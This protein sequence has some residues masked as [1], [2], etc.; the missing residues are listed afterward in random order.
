MASNLQFPYSKTIRENGEVIPAADH[1]KQETQLECLTDAIG[2]YDFT[3]G[4]VEERLTIIET[5]NDL[6]DL[7]D[8]VAPAPS[9]GQVLQFSGPD[10][11]PGDLTLNA[12]TDVDTDGTQ[13]PDAGDVLTFDGTIWGPAAVAANLGDLLDVDTTG[14]V[15]GQGLVF[16]SGEWSPELTSITVASDTPGGGNEQIA[17]EVTELRFISDSGVGQDHVATEVAPG[18]V[19][20]GAGAPPPALSLIAGLPALVAGR[21]SQN[22]AVYPPATVAGDLYNNITQNTSYIFNTNAAQFGSASLGVLILAINGVDVATLDLAANFVEL[23]RVAGQNVAADYNT[24][25][26]GDP[27]VSGVVTFVGG[28]LEILTVAPSGVVSID[29]FQQGMSRITLNTAGMVDGYNS[30]QLRH[31]TGITNTSNLLEW[32][33]DA[34]LPTVPTNPAVSGQTIVENTPVTKQL[35]GITYYDAGSTFDL[36]FSLLR[37]FNNV[38]HQTNIP[39]VLDVSDFGDATTG[40]AIT[41]PAVAGVST[42]P[43]RGE[44]MAVTAFSVA[45]GGGVQIFQPD[46]DITPRDPYGNY[47]LATASGNFAIMSVSPNSTDTLDRFVDE[48][49]RLPDSTDFDTPI[50][51]TALPGALNPSLWNSADDLTGTAAGGSLQVYRAEVVPSNRLAYPQTDY[52][53]AFEPQPNPDYS[54]LSPGNRTYYRVF[55][56]GTGSQ[57][58]GIITLPGLADADLG[59]GD[60]SIRLKVPGKTV[61]LDALIAFSAGTFPTGAPLIGGADGEGCRINSGVNSPSINGAIEFSLGAIGTDAGSDFQIIVEITYA[62]A[63]A[64]EIVGTGS[65]LSIN[66]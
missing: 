55:R 14:A 34:D 21:L 39:D 42:P 26:A 53:S 16:R 66:W 29:I 12:L 36:D 52:T 51:G 46:A 48:R 25:G 58:N 61:W 60:V 35:S 18:V 38:Y 59:P 11:V 41:D 47:T 17:T 37:P 62:D 1:N 13:T 57:T 28:T 44:T 5:N 3:G 54:G 32:F 31:V 15:D 64:T 43:D 40:I 27:M 56:S 23:N 22:A 65:G 20:I 8:V 7:G 45:A 2:N 30:A 4:S 10:W 19:Y 9:I 50:A 49:Y 6:N 63:A 33:Y 24:T